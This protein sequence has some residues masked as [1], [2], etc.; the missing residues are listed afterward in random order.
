MRRS[1][2]NL[3][4]DFNAQELE[5][6]CPVTRKLNR[7]NYRESI[8]IIDNCINKIIFANDKLQIYEPTTLKNTM[9]RNFSWRKHPVRFRAAIFLRSMAE[10]TK[11]DIL[12]KIANFIETYGFLKTFHRVVWHIFRK[13][14]LK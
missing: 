10:E 2:E 4:L 8:K 13:C 3:G 9:E 11:K 1:F 7:K 12:L 6:L 14:M 5:L